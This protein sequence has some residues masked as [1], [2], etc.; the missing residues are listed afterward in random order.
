MFIDTDRLTDSTAFSRFLDR[1]YR[2]SETPQSAGFSFYLEGIDV[3]V[4]EELLF[5]DG[6]GKRMGKVRFAT[7]IRTVP[8]DRKSLYRGVTMRKLRDGTTME[9][10][11]LFEKLYVDMPVEPEME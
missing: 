3:S 6:F 4:I 7:K 8:D 1:V 2:Y 10:Q 9:A 5:E 11:Y